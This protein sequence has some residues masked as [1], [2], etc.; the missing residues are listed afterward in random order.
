MGPSPVDRS[1]VLDVDRLQ[2]AIEQV[3]YGVSAMHGAGILHRDL[4]PSNIL[5][6]DEGRLVLLDFGLAA[7]L[8][9]RRHGRQ[10]LRIGT[11]AYMAP[12]VADGE[13]STPSSDWYAVG[14]LLFEALTGRVPF[15]GSPRQMIAAKRSRDPPRVHAL[16]PDAPFELATL[17]DALLRRDPDRR[18]PAAEVRR[19]LGIRAGAVARSAFV[20][21]EAELESLK[22]HVTGV[23][24]GQPRVV[25][26]T[27]ASGMGKSMLVEQF[28][29]EIH[30]D[31]DVLVF[32]G[33]CYERE[34]VPYKALD[35]LVD[36]IA[37]HLR[38][39]PAA[40]RDSYQPEN[41]AALMRVF[42]SF[43][44]MFEST[45]ATDLDPSEL[46]RR[47]GLALRELLGSLAEHAFV[48]LHIDDLQ[49]GDADSAAILSVLLQPPDAPAIFVLG[50][51]RPE[52]ED[53][54]VYAALQELRRMGVAVDELPVEGLDEEAARSMLSD[55][56]DGAVIDSL[57]AEAHGTPFLLD[58]LARH[59][60]EYG[61]EATV[62]VGAIVA[63]RMEKL[64]AV[65]LRLLEFIA[66]AGQPVERSLLREATELPGDQ[67]AVAHLVRSHL[68]RSMGG[69]GQERVVAYHDSIR[70]TV[71][72][73]LGAGVTEIH[74][75]IAD[76]M[77][78]LGLDVE[79]RFVH[80]R[81]A[82]HRDRA[83]VLAIEAA[84]N[85]ADLLAFGHAADLFTQA[86]ELGEQSLQVHH[87]RAV[88]LVNAGRPYAAGEAYLEAEK[89]APE[90][91]QIELRR[92][93]AE[94]FL[95]GGHADRG[96]EVMTSVLAS[97]GLSLASSPNTALAKLLWNRTRLW[98]R[99]LEY[100]LVD[101]VSAEDL[102]EVDTLWSVASA[103]SVMDTIR[104][105]DFQV[106]HLLRALDVGEP[107]RIC[108]ALALEG[109]YSVT[110]NRSKLERSEQILASAQQLADGL[111]DPRGRAIVQLQ[112][113]IRD[114]LVGDW[115]ASC[116]SLEK[117]EQLVRDCRG[118]TW[119]LSQVV[120]FH[121]DALSLRGRWD[122]L[123]R[124]IPPRLTEARRNGNLQLTHYLEYARAVF[125]RIA[126]DDPDTG[127]SAM[128]ETFV[129][130][131]EHGFTTPDW[132]RMMGTS[133]LHA[134]KGDSLAA[135]DA[136]EADWPA[137]CSSLLLRVDVMSVPG[138]YHRARLAL[139]RAQDT[140][141]VAYVSLARRE[142]ALIGKSSNG[143]GPAL[144]QLIDGLCAY[145]AGDEAG[146]L[147]KLEAAEE[148]LNALDMRLHGASV[149]YRRGEW[150]GDAEGVA[151]AVTE[152]RSLGIARPDRFAALYAPSPV[153]GVESSG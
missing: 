112:R 104:A 75:R 26:V 54:D 87:R 92:A 83:R 66:V 77:D 10:K 95:A 149:R 13:V 11:P 34:S 27:G 48:A 55:R 38:S 61:G 139:G 58:A 64:P 8:A 76:A 91:E 117:A 127:L 151:A 113:G 36:E 2:N 141:D 140:G 78:R 6:D 1:G 35:E 4:K 74:G 49:W 15:L 98:W 17:A 146:A 18:P 60:S 71:V 44:G 72:G 73:V 68:V 5:V 101:R 138:R 3:V 96:V 121:V 134:Y 137:L 90:S 31:T 25:L 52:G 50:T 116:V 103:M 85:A 82:G 81:A 109:P 132:W 63:S 67:A 79:R 126:Q 41:D 56:V 108:R 46:R 99:G 118:M 129:H 93:A 122:Q 39:L 111:E 30:D 130:R 51:M 28:L 88:A 7:E 65:A 119:E 89:R 57:L 70:E 94:Q 115:P 9:V 131:A 23:L 69:P 45:S 53:T 100:Q 133:L 150:S 62:S 124:V 114:F 136:W 110:E 20:G 123:R 105:T 120:T 144:G 107:Y 22:H 148:R 16:A 80:R 152:M 142:A 97:L 14:C 43:D 40:E 32:S 24:P 12:E 128:A 19:V 147:A 106:R 47:A 42:Q 125:I 29:A 86:I 153:K 102:L 33:R 37:A 59:I 145:H 84:E 21:R 143:W 135:W